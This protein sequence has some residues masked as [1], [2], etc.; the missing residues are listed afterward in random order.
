MLK[1]HCN[2]VVGGPGSLKILTV[3]PRYSQFWLSA[4]EFISSEVRIPSGFHTLCLKTQDI[5][6]KTVLQLT[7]SIVI[8]WTILPK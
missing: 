7:L 6:V 4:V 2:E 8:E 3:T 1:A 5:F